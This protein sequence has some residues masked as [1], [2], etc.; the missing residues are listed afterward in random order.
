M[1]FQAEIDELYEKSK[2]KKMSQEARDK[3]EKEIKKLKMMSPMSAEAA[4]IRNY[5]DWVLTLPWYDYSVE[6]LDVIK[7]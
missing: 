7:S 1:T 6:T 5:I 3:I 4:V 2:T